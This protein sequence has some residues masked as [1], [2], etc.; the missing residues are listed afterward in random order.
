MSW[1]WSVTISSR[2]VISFSESSLPLVLGEAGGRLLLSGRQW[3]E[4]LLVPRSESSGAYQGKLNSIPYAPMY[5]I[6]GFVALNVSSAFSCRVNTHRR[7]SAAASSPRPNPIRRN[8]T[9]VWSRYPTPPSFAHYA[10][11]PHS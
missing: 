5:E 6:N 3:Q 1:I 7:M 11:E 4:V 9:P 8:K 10:S 2:S